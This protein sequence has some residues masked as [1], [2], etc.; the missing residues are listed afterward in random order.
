MNCAIVGA[1]LWLM[2]WLPPLRHALEANMAT[3]MIVQ[4]PLLAVAGVLAAPMVRRYEP[5]WLSDS[6]W[7]GIPG[8]VLVLFSTSYW[9]LPL[10][11]D[12][13]LTDWRVE[14][15]KFAGLAVTVGLPLGLSWQRMPLLGRAF[16]IAN[17]ISK[18]GAVGG[19]FLAAP[20]RLCA[21]YRVDQQV[22]AGWALIGVSV[23]TGLVWF[24]GA[25]C[26]WPCSGTQPRRTILPP[27]QDASSYAA[28]RVLPNITD[29][30]E[31]SGAAHQLHGLH[32]ANVDILGVDNG[33]TGDHRG[34]FG[35]LRHLRRPLDEGGT[36]AWPRWRY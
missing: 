32:V 20:I 6:D 21:Y 9:M 30:M 36:P 24:V 27:G 7:L 1:V 14:A 29:I 8:L 3:H 19:L 25:F 10:A 33:P 2:L 31:S 26:G 16:V 34:N 18:L 15:L 28:S 5:R 13:A 23:V 35:A 4:L 17:I 22:D 12:A 11:L